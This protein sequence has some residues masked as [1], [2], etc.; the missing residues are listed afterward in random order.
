MPDGSFATLEEVIEHYRHP[1]A[2]KASPE[3]TPLELD[4]EEGRALVAFLAA[5]DG[6]VATAEPWL[7]APPRVARPNRP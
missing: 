1:P 2:S 3:I 6:G 4:D 7:R 5:L